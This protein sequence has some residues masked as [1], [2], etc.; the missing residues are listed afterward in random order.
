M[1]SGTLKSNR[2][3]AASRFGWTALVALA[4]LL[5]VFFSAALA[6]DPP[7]TKEARQLQKQAERKAE[8]QKQKQLEREKARKAAAAEA[9]KAAATPPK[10]PE[11]TV[12][13]PTLTSAELDSLITAYLSK[14]SPDVRPAPP[15]SDAEF[16]RRVSLDVAGAPPAAE[17]VEAF[18]ADKSPEKRARLVDALLADADYARNWARYWREVIQFRATNPNPGQVRYDELEDWLADRLRENRPWDEIARELITA[19]GR[20]DE[21]GAVGF[22]LAHLARPV[23]MAGEVSRVFMGVQIQCAE[24]HN[25]FTDSWKR[26]QFHEFAAF[27]SGSRVRRVDKPEPGKRA[28]FAVETL[29]KAGYAMPVKNDPTKKVPIQPKFFLASAE[30]AAVEV[31]AKLSPKDLHELAASLITGQDNP[32]FARAFVNRIWTVLMGEGFYEVV[33]DLGPERT[34]HGAEILFPLADQWQKGG[35]DIQWLF[36]TILNTEAYQR[37]ARPSSS[38]AGEAALAANRANRLRA[39]QILESL[40]SA[41]GLS[42]VAPTADDAKDK[43]KDKAKNKAKAEAQ[44]KNDPPRQAAPRPAFNNL[45]G[46]DPSVNG[47][48]V[49]GTIPQALFLMNGPVVHNR[50]L[51]RGNTELA[52]ILKDSTDNAAA[53]DELYLLVLARRPTDDEAKICAEFLTAAKDRKEAFEDI[54]WSLVNSAEFLSRR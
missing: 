39:D 12:V 16:I 19:T 37:R 31:P 42:S 44:A 28:V 15:T 24:C 52:R 46:V 49:L 50:T 38:P 10:R 32:W 1:R 13:P 5:G 23:E 4:C 22:G 18:V 45:F 17:E 25:H 41:L 47:D 36:R 11:R 26:E 8:R 6:E 34:P 30:T 2:G 40:D 35:Y 21:N 53:L 14:A 3:G 43:P 20:V 7:T 48:E 51:A 54:Y 33:D 9:A 29:P 27:F